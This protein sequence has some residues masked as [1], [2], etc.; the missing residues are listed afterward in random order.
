[1]SDTSAPT[2][3]TGTGEKNASISL[4]IDPAAF[5]QLLESKAA[6]DESAKST[7]KSGS[8][9]HQ[10]KLQLS[11]LT[12]A[13]VHS[14]LGTTYF[15]DNFSATLTPE[16]SSS[17]LQSDIHAELIKQ[18]WADIGSLALTTGLG[19][20]IDIKDGSGATYKIDATQ[21]V[22]FKSLTFEGTIT[23]DFSG[24]SPNVTGNFSVKYEF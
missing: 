4:Q 5:E 8:A 20:D 19:G 6:G 18:K 12:W 3:P 23:T 9:K 15:L 21:D 14:S 10:I 13:N 7:A 2:K 16:S 17:P 1:M 24:S 22:K 11:D